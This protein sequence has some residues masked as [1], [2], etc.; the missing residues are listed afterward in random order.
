[1]GT[2]PLLFVDHGHSILNNCET[3]LKVVLI[4]RKDGIQKF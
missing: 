3:R 1:M 2:L 4:Y